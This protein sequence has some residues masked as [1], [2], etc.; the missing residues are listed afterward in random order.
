[1]KDASI[2]DDCRTQVSPRIWLR[3]T[4]RP[5][6]AAHNERT[7]PWRLLRLAQVADT[8]QA[9]LPRDLF[10]KIDN[11]FDRTGNLTVRVLPQTSSADLGAIR[12]AVVQVWGEHNE[13]SSEVL[14]MEG[15]RMGHKGRPN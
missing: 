10:T 2:A 12:L 8:L 9:R 15:L 6:L 13:C 7:E 4:L 5:S 14:R 1:M 11:L 3:T